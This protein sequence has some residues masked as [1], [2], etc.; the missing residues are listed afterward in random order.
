MQKKVVR[1]VRV[2]RLRRQSANSKRRASKRRAFSVKP[3]ACTHYTPSRLLLL[4]SRCSKHASRAQRPTTKTKVI[5]VV[6]SSRSVVCISCVFGVV[7]LEMQITQQSSSSATHRLLWLLM[8]AS[9]CLLLVCHA[10]LVVI[11]PASSSGVG[12]AIRSYRRSLVAVLNDAAV[13]NQ[14]NS[15]VNALPNGQQ[16][17]QQQ[18]SDRDSSSDNDDS[19]GGNGAAT[20]VV[21]D[22]PPD[23]NNFP[24]A[25]ETS[26]SQQLD[27]RMYYDEIKMYLVFD[28]NVVPIDIKYI[29]IW[30]RL[31]Q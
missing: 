6:C 31:P 28:I 4:A 24:N 3:L 11:S 18:Q 16:Q 20:T 14:N 12:R 13:G 27:D 7:R 22:A 5:S 26:N 1:F 8:A 10:D 30:I 21:D 2:A 17:R 23:E 9:S 29:L 15:S 25:V 19:A